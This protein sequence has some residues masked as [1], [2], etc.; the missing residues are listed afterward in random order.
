MYQ[1]MKYYD[2]I[3]LMNQNIFKHFKGYNMSFEIKHQSRQTSVVNYYVLK[4][5]AEKNLT[6]TVKNFSQELE[7]MKKKR[8]WVHI[9]AGYLQIKWS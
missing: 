4:C 5:K 1:Y 9:L 8:R 7:S 2:K 6:P 3:P